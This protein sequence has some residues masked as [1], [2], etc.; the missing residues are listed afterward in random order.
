[1]KIYN[2]YGQLR[3][4][5]DIQAIEHLVKLK[6]KNLSN[7][8][9]VVEE[10]IRIW[11]SKKP[12][13]YKSFLIDLQ[14]MRETR[15][16]KYGTSKTGMFRYTLDIPETVHHMLRKLYTTQEMPMDKKFFRD[17]ARRFPKMKVAERI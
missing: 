13:E 7:Y 11:A 17:W 8:W 6:Q 4:T 14:D 12:R 1:M 15:S 16:D 3:D 10:C 2:A 9:P 5:E